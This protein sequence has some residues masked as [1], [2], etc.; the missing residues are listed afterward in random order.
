MWQMECLLGKV[1]VGKG[2][3]AEIR[4]V[5]FCA[6]LGGFHRGLT[7]AASVAARGGIEVDFTCVAASELEND[8]R[9]CYVQNFPDVRHSY[10]DLRYDL[11]GPDA[12]CAQPTASLLHAQPEF[13]EKGR[14]KK[15]HGD[16]T[17][18]LD[19]K[20]TGLRKGSSGVPLLPAHDLFCAG[21]PCQPFSKSGAQ[22]GFEDTRGTVFHAIATILKEQR[23][24]FVLL[25]NVGNFARHDEGNTWNRVRKI[26]ETDLGYDV[27]ATEHVGSGS[28]SAS[29]LLSPHHLGYPHHRE[30][31]FI[32]AQRKKPL[33]SDSSI[34]KV[35][36][37]EPLSTKQSFPSFRPNGS[38]TNSD[39]AVLDAKAK[40]ALVRIIAQDKAPREA[41]SLIAAQVTPDRVRCIA[42]WGKLLK[43]LEEL[44]EQGANP[45]FRETMP[46][47]PIWGYELD[48]WHW[49]PIDR[50][51]AD[52]ST[53]FVRIARMRQAL[54]LDARME[55]HRRTEKAVDLK[56]F[57]PEGDRAWL[58]KTFTAKRTL[59]WI[60]TWPS[61]AG[62]REVWP[63]WKK[64][65]IEQNREWALRLWSE[66][67]PQ[68]LRNWLE[69]LYSV[70]S[71]PSYQK[72]EWNCKGEPLQIWDQILQFRPSGLRVKRL[73]HVP[74]LVAMTTT[75]IPIVPRLNDG[76]SL[77]GAVA[78]SRGRHLVPSEALQLQGFPASWALPANRERAF[79][80]FGNAVHAGVVRDIVSSWLLREAIFTLPTDNPLPDSTQ[81]S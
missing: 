47:F 18:F 24:A 53:H 29:G 4:F 40:S 22:K 59:Q 5:D 77:E 14:L 55:V 12:G 42:H 8:L 32:L 75:Q 60:E 34:V 64:R 44:D 33:S 62:K 73:A 81:C 69:E 43:K 52:H 21:F 23:P 63:Q 36:L 7:T 35:L 80:G 72:L 11:G 74:A 48:P 3:R 20:Q 25:E 9:E 57:P 56:L 1:S 13:D 10:Q 38:R 78:Q 41:A 71:V 65:F 61:Y 50:N 79:T 16:M 58:A 76:E 37:R 70:I 51:P 28:G 39:R 27:I 45:S 49:Y 19:D 67:D 2:R 6:G 26:L 31:F 30:R 46:S 66:V 68:W 17:W 54:F 15:I